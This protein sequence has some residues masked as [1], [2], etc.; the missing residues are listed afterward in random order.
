MVDAGLHKRLLVPELLDELPADDPRARRSRRD[1]KRIN[2]WMMQ[3]SIMA[4]LLQF[5]GPIP[6]STILELGCGDGTFMLRVARKLAQ[7][8]SGVTVCLLDRQ[9]LVTDET[10]DGFAAL[11]WKT[12]IQTADV[13][14]ALQESGSE[15]PDIIAV[16][17]FLHHFDATALRSLLA[18]ASGQTS[19][20]AACEPRR[21]GFALAASRMTF[22]IGAN[23]VTRHDAVVSVR[24][25]FR[26]KELSDLWP[27]DA[28]AN[29]AWV[30]EEASSGL[31]THIFA[32]RRVEEEGLCR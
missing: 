3:S 9:N 4:R 27:S 12:K 2:G 24:A 10:R 17:L 23:D 28:N 21:S 14:D 11:G 32:A 15:K 25:G 20:L 31:F 22:A 8:W 30:L 13:F 16:N 6:P 1:L 7:H 26:G 19:F 18:M 5:Y 29:E